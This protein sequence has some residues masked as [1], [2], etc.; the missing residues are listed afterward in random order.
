M[1]TIHNKSDIEIKEE[2]TFKFLEKINEAIEYNAK[3]MTG[4]GDENSYKT[5]H[6]YITINFGIIAAASFVFGRG[7]HLHPASQILS[8][9]LICSFFAIILEIIYRKK[10]IS[11]DIKIIKKR[12]KSLE[13]IQKD[14]VQAVGNNF[15]NGTV[16]FCKMVDSYNTE[17]NKKVDEIY[18][19]V[20]TKDKNLSKYRKWSFWLMIISIFSLILVLLIESGALQR[21]WGFL[22]NYRS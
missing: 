1:E 10:V 14:F 21:L 6:F 20:T 4:L 17:Y 15:N 18:G 8:L 7:S 19:E 12:L 2:V 22:K 3:S 9:F 16:E 5:S 13:G 11:V